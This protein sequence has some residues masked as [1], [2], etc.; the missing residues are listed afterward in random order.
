MVAVGLE[1]VPVV[2]VNV[3]GDVFAFEDRC[4]H[5][6]NPLSQGRFDG[7]VLTC[8]A[9]EWTFDAGGGQGINPDRACLRAYAVLVHDDVI[10]VNLQEVIC[11]ERGLSRGDQ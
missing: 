7:R 4:P 6:A 2:L 11:V 5:A 10:Y 9:H 3:E 1:S 8:A